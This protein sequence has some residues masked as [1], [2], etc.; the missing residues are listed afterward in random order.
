MKMQ[1]NKSLELITLLKDTPA[2]KRTLVAT[3]PSLILKLQHERSRPVKLAS[4]EGFSAIFNSPKKKKKKDNQGM[5][6][7]IKDK[8]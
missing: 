5:E 4:D 8:Q 1:N 3:W 2:L 7:D 6:K